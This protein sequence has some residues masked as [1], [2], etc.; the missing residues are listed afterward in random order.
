LA[1]IAIRGIQRPRSTMRMRLPAAVIAPEKAGEP[2]AAEEPA[3]VADEPAAR[4]AAEEP[5]GELAAEEPAASSGSPAWPARGLTSP[6]GRMGLAL[7]DGA[8][9]AADEPCGEGVEAAL[10]VEA[11]AGAAEE[12]AAQMPRGTSAKAGEELLAK[13]CGDEAQWCLTVELVESMGTSMKMLAG[14]V[15]AKAV[16]AGAEASCTMHGAPGVEGEAAATKS[17]MMSGMSS[18]TSVG[19]V[20]DVVDSVTRAAKRTMDRDN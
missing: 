15:Q 3:A 7:T 16:A 13:V 5:A 17:M 20:V 10:A 19:T 6:S 11:L 12:L 4:E 2:G 1:S 18:R 9:A 14:E 8:R